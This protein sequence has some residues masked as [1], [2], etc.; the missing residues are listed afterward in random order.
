MKNIFSIKNIVIFGIAFV[1]MFLIQGY[2]I[3]GFLS[4]F[5]FERVIF[6]TVVA[7]LVTMVFVAGVNSTFKLVFNNRFKIGGIALILLTIMQVH[8]SSINVY[9]N[10]IQPNSYVENA[11]NI[12]GTSR[13]VR[14]DEWV[15][16]TPI[17]LSQSFSDNSYINDN[18]RATDTDMFAVLRSPVNSIV[19]L[20]VIFNLGYLVLGPA[21]GLAFWWNA[22]LVAVILASIE[23]F[24]V[25]TNKNYKLSAWAGLLVGLSL[26]VT[27]WFSTYVVDQIIVGF[28]AIAFT[29]YFLNAKTKFKKIL[30]AILFWIAILNYGF[31]MYL[32]TLV[33]FTY[34]FLIIFIW[35]II[36]N[37][38]K[39]DRYDI[40]GIGIGFLIFLI[41]CITFIMTSKEA[42]DL[43]LNTTYPGKRTG[44]EK[45]GRINYMFS[46]IYTFFFKGGTFNTS[47]PVPLN[48][49]EFSS[50]ITLFPLTYFV[51]IYYIIKN[52]DR[53]KLI[54]PL[55]LLVT[56]FLIY[57]YFGLNVS[58]T[59]LIFFNYTTRPRVRIA[60][61]LILLIMM[62][63]M[64]NNKSVKG[65]LSLNIFMTVS[66]ILS[67]AV[68]IYFNQTFYKLI[69]E[70][71][72]KN[73]IILLV[74][75]IIFIAF[76]I[77]YI[78]AYKN[79]NYKKLNFKFIYALLTF[80]LVLVGFV[81][82]N[83]V[84]KSID[85]F[86]EKP[87]AIEIAEL[88]KDD[89]GKWLTVTN[90]IVHSNY[91]LSQGVE[92]INSTNFYPN[93]DLLHKLDQDEQYDEVYNR[94]AHVLYEITYEET[95]YELIQADLYKVFINIEDLALLDVKYIYVDHLL[96]EELVSDIEAKLIYSEDGA[97]IYEL[98][99]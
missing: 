5:I 86:T 63:L 53:H 36:K 50:F 26:P 32:A 72:S 87:V 52:R 47:I 82:A 85:V 60:S 18:L 67:S 15:V 4:N 21:Y 80:G 8:G 90:S 6:T 69:F 74:G 41:A 20:G 84:S 93:F 29:Y 70:I 88:E 64:L 48:T 96:N 37:R 94:Y 33:P 91:V 58:F 79:Y 92:V 3:T 14:S 75:A 2:F 99:D 10:Y 39:L 65:K 42:I 95:S 62:V 7:L 66:L 49:S 34:M 28:A 54:L 68:F 55:F 35:V 57:Q 97:F 30:F 23:F 56:F 78:L 59:E 19:S 77:I 25:L 24:I 98:N 13:D 16:Q 44:M 9:D 71:Y 43:I 17:N 89:S 31:S 11:K 40:L 46:Y 45:G 22:R 38:R 1:F 73:F 76:G 61:E 51:S 12:Y 27:W 83:P 81:T